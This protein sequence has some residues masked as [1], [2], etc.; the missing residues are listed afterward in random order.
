[1]MDLGKNPGCEVVEH[2]ITQAQTGTAQ[3]FVVFRNEHND[4]ITYFKA[5]TDK[6]FEYLVKDLKAMG[7][8][9]ETVGWDLS[10][11]AKGECLRGL[12]A[13]LEV[14]DHTYNGK[15][16]RRVKWVNDPNG[17]FD[18]PQLDPAKG[19]ELFSRLRGLAYTRGM[20][21]QGG[22]RPASAPRARSAPRPTPEASQAAQRAQAPQQTHETGIDYDDIPFAWLLPFLVASAGMLA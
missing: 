17:G 6:T 18:R 10:C 9:P 14:E 5:M 1:M 3:L 2:G 19:A 7:F 11:L 15:T 8:D 13:D 22:S 16:S 12:R 20:A 4:E 21:K